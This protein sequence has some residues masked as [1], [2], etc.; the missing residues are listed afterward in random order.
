MTVSKNVE[1]TTLQQ[2]DPC[3][4]TSTVTSFLHSL[5]ASQD[6]LELAAKGKVQRNVNYFHIIQLNF[7]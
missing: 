4:L 2:V 7:L 5:L 6:L 1:K 3:L